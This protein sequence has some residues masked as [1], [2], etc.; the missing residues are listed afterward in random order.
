MEVDRRDKGVVRDEVAPVLVLEYTP[1][2]GSLIEHA[3]QVTGNRIELGHLQHTDDC[4]VRPAH[5]VPTFIGAVPDK[6][7]RLLLPPVS[8]S[9][10]DVH[11]WDVRFDLLHDL[12]VVQVD[13]RC[14]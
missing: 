7:E 1:E 12:L 14:G 13:D 3:D 5:Q 11:K 6:I 9:A 4:V 2:Q 8:S 10:A